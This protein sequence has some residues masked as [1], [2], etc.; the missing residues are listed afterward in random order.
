MSYNFNEIEKKWQEYWDKNETFKTDVW[1]FSKPKYYALDMFPYPSGQGLHVGHPEGYTATDIMSRMRRMQGYNVL[2]P[3]GWDAFG[4]PAEQ[5]AIKTGNHPAGFT[6]KNIATFKKQLK[7]LGFSFDWSREISTCEPSYY[8]WT[9]WIF[10]QLY[11]DGLAKLVEMPVNWCEG[12]GCVLSNDEVINGKS[13]RGGFPVVRKNMKQWVMDIPKY[14]E[15]LLDGL[16]ELDWP[17]STKEIQ[18]NWIGKSVG[19]EVKFKVVGTDKEFTVFTTRADTL[20]GATYCVLSPEHELVD[21]ITNLKQKEAIKEYKA[22]AAAKSDLERTELNKE[23]TGCFTGAYAIN[24]VNAKEIPIWISDYVLATYGTGAIMAVPAHDE[25]D[26]EFAKK[27]GIEIIPVLEGGDISKEAFTGDGVH[28]NSDFLN[29]LGKQEAIDKMIAWL[30]EKGIGD[31][32]VN[33]KLREWIF[34]RQRYWGEPIPIVFTE[35]DEI[36]VLADEDLPL[37]LPELEDYAPSKTGAS[38]L[39]KATDWVNTTFEGKPARRET[40]TM[41]GSAGSSWYFLRYIDPHNENEIAVPEL[42]K[43]WMPVDLYVGG[44][45]HAV[46]HLLYSRFWN[47]Y[48]YNKGIA[49][50]KEPFAKLRHQGMILGSNGEKMSKSKGNV[51]NPDDMVKEYGADALRVYEMFMGPIDAAKPWDPNGID[52]SKKF[53]DR[54]WRLLVESGKV[55]ANEHADGQ[56]HNKSLDKVYNYTVKKVTSDYENMYF[57]TAISQ[58]MIFVNTASK[59]D[60]IPQEYAEGFIKLLSPVAPHIAEEIW[61]R[62]GHNDTITYEAWP[63]YDESK[64]VEDTIEIPVQINGKVRATIQITVDAAEEDVKNSVH[65]NANIQAQFEGKNV[66][67]EIYVKNKI[68]NIVVK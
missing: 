8:K 18:R 35:G 67:K 36:H 23:K 55:Q 33:Y 58:M 54:V 10:K 48:L 39:D 28:I 64:L 59:E 37:V 31:K 68:Y 29:G 12:L 62:L 19:A 53:L 46:G 52:G 7:M 26:Y 5:Y 22:K 34:A 32:K 56:A 63:T 27:F 38:P 49:P 11:N 65:E 50:T 40:S 13:E 14:A 21:E 9:Q 61:N 66:V 44:P 30:E 1:D 25:R 60:V 47:N 57:N 6:K 43:H 20:F 3:M 24:P 2:H 17:E 45:E 42:L 16:D 4:L 41:P 15:I 51:I